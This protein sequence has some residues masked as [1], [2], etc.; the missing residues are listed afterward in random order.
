MRFLLAHE[1][2]IR[3]GIFTGVLG[4]VAAA[5]SFF[6][7]RERHFARLA[8]WP[9]NLLL[10]AAGSVMLRLL[11]PLLAVGVAIWAEAHNI[12]FFYW[13]GLPGWAGFTASLI[14]LDGLVYAQHVLMHRMALLWRF[15]RVHHSDRD[16]DTTT[17]LRF[18]PGEIALSMGLKMLAVIALG[19]PPEAVVIFEIVLNGTAMFNHANLFLA[20]AIEHILRLFIVTPGMHRI[21]HSLK[22]EEM[23]SNYGFNLSLWDQL[24]STY[25]PAASRSDFTLGLASY[26]STEPNGPIFVLLL[27]FWRRA[28]R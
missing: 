15:H 5:E 10:S 6:P 12:G 18:H 23:D 16:V 22:R 1:A 14:L 3:F 21:H 26:Q 4:L 20:P 28:L 17:A 13:I 27:P 2:A 7:A 11:F 8:R 25:R 9:A 24:F 19:A